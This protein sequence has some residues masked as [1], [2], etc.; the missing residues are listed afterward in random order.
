MFFDVIIVFDPRHR[1]LLLIYIVV[2]DIGCWLVTL[3]L[4]WYNVINLLAVI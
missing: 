1:D 3:Y 2:I 4:Q